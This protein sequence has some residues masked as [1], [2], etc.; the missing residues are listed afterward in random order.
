[1]H[2]QRSSSLPV[3]FAFS[4]AQTLGSWQMGQRDG[5]T[6]FIGIFLSQSL[7]DD[8][9]LVDVLTIFKID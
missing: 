3:A 4:M 8:G 1:M 7:I 5:S 6:I 2:K 9:C